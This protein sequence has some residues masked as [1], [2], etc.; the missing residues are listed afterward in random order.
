MSSQSFLPD[1]LI[2]SDAADVL[3]F[4]EALIKAEIQSQ[5]AFSAWLKKRSDLESFVSEDFAWRYIR[6]TCNTLDETIKANYLYFVTEIQP[7]LA[8]LNDQLNQKML[9]EAHWADNQH[10]ELMLYLKRVKNEADLFREENISLQT[11]AQEL[12]Q[13]YSALQGNMTVTHQDQV[14]TLSQA[15]LLL[16]ENNRALRQEVYEKIQQRRYSD[17][18]ALSEIYT[19]LRAVRHQ[20]AVNSGFLNFRDYMFTALNRFDYT[21]EDCFQFH[22]SVRKYIVP[23]AAKIHERRKKALLLDKLRPFDMDADPFGRK[24]LKPFGNA[25]ELLLKTK[26]CLAKTDAFFEYTLNTLEE[27]NQL[28]LDSRI[29]KAPGGYNY[30]LSKTGVPFIFMNASGSLRDV[31]TLIHEAGHAVHSLLT[32]NLEL[33]AYKETSAEVAELASMSMEL[34][35]RPHWSEF[36]SD[37]SDLKRALNEQLEDIILTLPWIATIDRFQHEVYLNPSE[38]AEEI[39][40]R[41]KKISEEFSTGKIDYSGYEH[42]TEYSWQR[43][44]HLYE[45]PFYYIEYGF[46]QLGALAIW[47]RNMNEGQPAIEDYKKALEA[48]YTKSIPEIY[49]LAGIQFD[50]S[51]RYIQD[52][53]LF[54]EK[55]IN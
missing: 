1:N 19:K 53:A 52:I 36:F 39:N 7:V 35:T 6:M 5:E 11:E 8:P 23:L 55:Q 9:S 10:K 12:A 32:R 40:L 25:E 41:W 49:N 47:M 26:A 46:A 22:E 31:E 21:P 3:P 48:G 13:S 16:K 20:M 30:P 24:P 29:G 33:S 51:D 15:A 54:M 37:E 42:F 45:V 28:D 50:F 34:L 43:Q 4:F 18:D 38:S 17:K 27:M 2:L 14:L 44:L